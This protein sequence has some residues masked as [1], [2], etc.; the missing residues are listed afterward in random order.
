[1]GAFTLVNQP[2][3]TASPPPQCHTYSCHHTHNHIHRHSYVTLPHTHTLAVTS[4]PLHRTTSFLLCR[5][6]RVQD[7]GQSHNGLLS[8]HLMHTCCQLWI[9]LY[10]S[11]LKHRSTHWNMYFIDISWSTKW[12]VEPLHRNDNINSAEQGDLVPKRECTYQHEDQLSFNVAAQNK[13]Q[14]RQSESSVNGLTWLLHY[15]YHFRLRPCDHRSD[16]SLRLQSMNLITHPLPF[17]CQR[18]LNSQ[19]ILFLH[20]PLWD[21]EH[22]DHNAHSKAAVEFLDIVHFNLAVFYSEADCPLD[23]CTQLSTSFFAFAPL[24]SPP[25]LLLSLIR[26]FWKDQNGIIA[27]VLYM[28]L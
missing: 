10:S 2:P 15:T 24:P 27:G 3:L 1:M 25:P 22:A 11:Y 5:S 17:A 14:H 20:Q 13:H 21:T 18:K 8:P 26:T 9:M 7:P 12:I 28:L 4:S 19:F 16:C 23:D 6:T